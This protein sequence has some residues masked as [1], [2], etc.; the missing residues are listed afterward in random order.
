MNK[1]AYSIDEAVTATGLSRTTIY[2]AIADGRLRRKK[3]GRRT[4]ILAT[5][6]QRFLEKLPEG[7]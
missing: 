1:V 2:E 3:A 6:L 5:E 4:I 7:N